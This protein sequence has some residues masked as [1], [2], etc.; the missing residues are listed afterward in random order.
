[1]NVDTLPDQNGQRK[2]P[3]LISP[4]RSP[5][6]SLPKFR[7]LFVT[8]RPLPLPNGLSL[9]F[10]SVDRFAAPSGLSCRVLRVFTLSTLR[11]VTVVLFRHGRRVAPDFRGGDLSFSRCTPSRRT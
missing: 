5:I 4:D 9:R 1:M 10:A 2:F 6:Y 3:P 8:Y 11:I 7:C